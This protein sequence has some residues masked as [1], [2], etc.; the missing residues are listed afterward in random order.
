MAG[1]LHQSNMFYL[2]GVL[3]AL[4]VTV[5]FALLI[6]IQ[7]REQEGIRIKLESDLVGLKSMINQHFMA[8]T[9]NAIKAL[10]NQGKTESADVYLTK[11]SAL[12]RGAL[13]QAKNTMIPLEEELRFIRLYIEL[14][15][16]RFPGQIQ[17]EYSV[18]PQL[19][20]N[21][22][23]VPAMLLQPILENS[24][25]HGR[26]GPDCPLNISLTLFP[27]AERLVILLQDDGIGI[28]VGKKNKQTNRQD[29][30][31]IDLTE[32][33]I[34]LLGNKYKV[35]VDFNVDEVIDSKGMVSGTRVIIEVPFTNTS[36]S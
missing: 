11:F 36:Y 34:K 16:L 24:V 10:I 29:S 5:I 27:Q 17:F 26:R 23:L 7:K 20:T 32:Q 12:L 35:K 4:A 33:R 2:L 18:D 22:I 6:Y 30:F 1:H 25:Q 19:E 21:L 14:E 8:N 31:G 13:S 15:Q 28:K 3:L 9:M